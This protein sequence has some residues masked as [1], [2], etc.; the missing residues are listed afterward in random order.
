MHRMEPALTKRSYKSF[1]TNDSVIFGMMRNSGSRFVL[2]LINFNDDQSQI[3]DLSTEG[4]PAR[5][6]VKVIDGI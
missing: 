5:M 2:L 1:A 6:T 4:L 3:I